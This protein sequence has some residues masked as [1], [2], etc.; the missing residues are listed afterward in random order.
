[1]FERLPRCAKLTPAAEALAWSIAPHLDALE[2]ALREA[3]ARSGALSGTVHIAAPA[4]FADAVLARAAP[5][6]IAEGLQI[7]MQTG[8]RERLYAL[9]KESAVDLAITASEPPSLGSCRR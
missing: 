2:Q 4:E 8:G 9:L 3:K 7:R 5:A 6:L 1:M